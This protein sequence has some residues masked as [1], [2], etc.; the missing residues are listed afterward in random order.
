MSGCTAAVLPD[1]ERADAALALA[2]VMVGAGPYDAAPLSCAALASRPDGD[3]ADAG[4]DDAGEASAARPGPASFDGIASP[5]EKLKRHQR[6]AIYR[7]CRALP[8]LGNLIRTV[9]KLKRE[10]FTKKDVSLR[11]RLYRST[12]PCLFERK[13]CTRGVFE[14][15][16]KRCVLFVSSR[17]LVPRVRRPLFSLFFFFV[18]KIRFQSNCPST[19]RPRAMQ[20]FSRREPS[21]VHHVARKTWKGKTQRRAG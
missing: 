15:R 18:E 19:D 8:S 13:S 5:V 16:S 7:P 10:R 11:R 4:Y 6:C 12:T 20:I 9:P 3:G 14:Q 2:V 1:E 21:L 17:R